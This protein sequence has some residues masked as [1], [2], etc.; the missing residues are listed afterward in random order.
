M[1]AMVGLL[2]YGPGCL[3]EIAQSLGRAI[4]GCRKSPRDPGDRLGADAPLAAVSTP[5]AEAWSCD[6]LSEE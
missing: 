3:P 4:L 6:R 2:P 5:P 1:L